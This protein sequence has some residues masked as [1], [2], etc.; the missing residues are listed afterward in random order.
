MNTFAYFSSSFLFYGALL[1]R[2][3]EV[4]LDYFPD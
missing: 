2:G 3:E 1:G 4:D